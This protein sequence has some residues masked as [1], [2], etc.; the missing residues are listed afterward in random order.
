M[1]AKT[2]NKKWIGIGIVVVIVLVLIGIVWGSFNSLVGLSQ[3][4]DRSWADVETQY[5]RRIDLIPNLVNTVQSYAT[6]EQA[7]LTKITEL[8]SQWQATLSAE[9]RVKTANEVES[10]ISKLLLIAENYP[11]LKA[12]ANFVSLQ[13]SLAETENMVS[14]A[15]TRYNA[16]VRDYNSVVLYF[17]SNIV[18]GMFNFDMRSYFEAKPGAENV[19]VVNITV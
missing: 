2:S 14:V 7:T 5:Q 17:P 4:V 16:A 3:N 9:D 15:R 11:E 6:Y 1:A 8:R 12:S 13:D 18:A 10:A 19:P